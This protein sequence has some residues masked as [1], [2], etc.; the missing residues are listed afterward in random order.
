MRGLEKFY[1]I[2]SKKTDESLRDFEE[3]YGEYIR[4][5][6]IYSI[7]R[8]QRPE[9][10]SIIKWRRDDI[11]FLNIYRN[12]SEIQISLNCLRDI[13]IYIKSFPY[14]GKV[15]KSRYLYYHLENH[16]HEIYILYKRLSAF[17][18]VVQKA[19]SK[20]RRKHD[21]DMIVKDLKERI[22][23]FSNFI[24]IRG[25]HVHVGRVKYEDVE[26]LW[27]LEIAIEENPNN[28]D[29][30]RIYVSLISQAKREWVK[31]IQGI[32]QRISTIVDYYF[33]GLILVLFD[34]QERILYPV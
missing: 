22:Q 21:I 31:I 3:M 18:V 1:S 16:L 12:S 6:K 23:G 19:Y 13:E 30:E 2:L 32:N 5:A 27:A 33:D 7:L 20:D 10:K 28:K 11:F 26:Q 8:S 4:E 9:S 24:K 25:E 17:L 15:P 14:E 29:I 34:E